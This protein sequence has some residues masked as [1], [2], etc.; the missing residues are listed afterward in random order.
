M[1]GRLGA[2]GAGLVWDLVMAG[3]RGGGAR[4]GG[5]GSGARDDRIVGSGRDGILRA[6][7]ATHVRLGANRALESAA[8]LAMT[9]SI[10]F[11]CAWPV[12]V[13]LSGALS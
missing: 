6:V 5:G 13:P 4:D 9:L 2:V 12:P 8:R 7:G 1:V 10:R 3:A 11:R